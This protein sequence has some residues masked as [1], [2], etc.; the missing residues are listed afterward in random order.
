MKKFTKTLCLILAVITMLS[1]LP[2]TAFAA[3]SIVSGDYVYTVLEDGTAEIKN[4]TGSATE[5]TVPDTL[6]GYTVTSIGEDA[7]S[8]KNSL[9]SVTIPDTVTKIGSWALGFNPNLKSVHLPDSIT[10]IGKGVF[11][12]DEAL[13]EVNLPSRLTVIPRNT[14][15]YCS[16][17]TQIDIPAGVTEIGDE[18]FF[19]CSGLSTIALPSGL[20]TIGKDAF[21]SCTGLLKI[22]LP[23]L[24]KTVG[25]YAFFN[26]TVFNSVL[27]PASVETIGDHAF[28]WYLGDYN[29]VT[30]RTDFSIKGWADTAA[31][32]YAEDNGFPFTE[33]P[34]YGSP[35]TVTF[36]SGTGEEQVYDAAVGD[37]ITVPCCLFEREGFTFLNWRETQLGEVK[38]GELVTVLSDMKFTAVWKLD[39]IHDETYL[40]LSSDTSTTHLIGQLQLTDTRTGQVYSEELDG[41]T[42]S[43]AFSVPYQAADIETMKSQL[44]TA[45]QAYVDPDVLNVISDGIG[46]VKPTA[47]ADNRRFK[48]VAVTKSNGDEGKIM[49]VTG[50]YS[51]AWEVTVQLQAE[52]ESPS[53][54]FLCAGTTE[55]GSYRIEEEDAEDLTYG[56][57]RSFDYGASVTLTATPGEGYVFKGWYEGIR[58]D[59]NSG[60]WGFVGDYTDLCYSTETTYSFT[61]TRNTNICAVF[62]KAGSSGSLSGSVKS[63]LDEGETVCLT[64]DTPDTPVA[65]LTVTGNNSTYLFNNLPAGTYT[66]TVNKKNHVERAYEVTVSG[67]TVQDVKIC[68]KGDIS[69]DGKVTSKDSSMAFQKAQGKITLN[70]YQMKCGDVVK[71]DGKITSNDASRIFQHAQGRSL[72]Y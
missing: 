20:Q 17:L 58:G 2:M 60:Y 47:T 70:D 18:A 25:S 56:S 43:S 71:N 46:S 21:H 13:E 64:L 24:L 55:G 31:Q 38:S 40:D 9:V 45:A 36:L 22:T 62:E 65:Q 59:Q 6:D 50:S 72:M 39:G 37:I 1:L 30:K 29:A 53:V 14:F 57:N 5:I 11:S 68:P 16:S 66:L 23:S 32:Q 69:G 19:Q 41:G 27:I 54:V 44:L 3:D 15:D 48:Y 10:T 42:V 35:V 61:I 33:M 67:D 7:L 34:A 51:H 49:L 52:F 63:Y 26:C 4:Y 12:E 28:G 8:E